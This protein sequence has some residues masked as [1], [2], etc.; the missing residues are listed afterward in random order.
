[1]KNLTLAMLLAATLAVPAAHAQ[2][3]PAIRAAPAPN[4]VM[5]AACYVAD[6]ARSLQFYRDALGMTLVMKFG[7]P[8]RPDVVLGFG[9]DPTKP[10]VMLLS[11][12][13][14]PVPRK[15]EHGHGFDHLVLMMHDLPAIA[16]RLQA[17]GFAPGKIGDAHGM[18]RIMTVMDPDGYRI[19]LIESG[20]TK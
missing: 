8:D 2:T 19:E 9:S 11:D 4:A 7:P 13:S 18:A 12:R 10:S 5:G 3:A 17:A 6:M 20:A 14:A 1:M 16:A 15:I